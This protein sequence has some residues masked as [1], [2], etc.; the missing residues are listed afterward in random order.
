[1]FLKRSGGRGE[2]IR[3][4]CFLGGGMERRVFPSAFITVIF[5]VVGE[6]CDSGKRGLYRNG[7][8]LR[9]RGSSDRFA[10]RI[11]PASKVS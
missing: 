9:H 10:H 4:I 6:V 11:P 5:L 7:R 2:P 1:M 3:G 8:I